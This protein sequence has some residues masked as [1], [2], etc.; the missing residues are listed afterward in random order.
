MFESFRESQISLNVGDFA[1]A[2]RFRLPVL[3][4]GAFLRQLHEEK[5]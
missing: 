5:I 2:A 3:T 4:P 1:A